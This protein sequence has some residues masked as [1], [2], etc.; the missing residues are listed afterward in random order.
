MSKSVFTFHHS[1]DG[2]SLDRYYAGNLAYASDMFSFYV[3]HHPS[4]VMLLRSLLHAEDWE[5]MAFQLHKL[6]PSIA[7]V[8]LSG[9][10][11]ESLRLKKLIRQQADARLLN[12]LTET[13]LEDLQT[14]LPLIQGELSRM[15]QAM[16]N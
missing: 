4:Q 16:A 6:G 5:G 9:L 14:Q 1:L 3:Q 15:R 7:M 11:E 12:T 13:F 10:A 2:Y 8:G